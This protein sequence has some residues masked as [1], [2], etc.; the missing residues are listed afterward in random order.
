MTSETHFT[1]DFKEKDAPECIFNY[2][3]DKEKSDIAARYPISKLLVFMVREMAARRPQDSYLVT[4]NIVNPGLCHSELIKE[5]NFVMQIMKFLLARIA[6]EGL[7]TL[8]H[9]ASAGPET[10]GQY[11]NKCRAEQPATVVIGMAQRRSEESGT[12]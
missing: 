11:L 6:E 8:V 1:V 4:I 12:R 5:D 9:G 2:L 7:W 10:H 3:N